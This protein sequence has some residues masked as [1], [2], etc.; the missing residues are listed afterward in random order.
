MWNFVD[1]NHE[2]GFEDVHRKSNCDIA[3]QNMKVFL[4]TKRK[5]TSQLSSEQVLVIICFKVVKK[6]QE[7]RF[8]SWLAL[9]VCTTLIFKMRENIFNIGHGSQVFSTKKTSQSFIF[10]SF[11]V[12]QT[13]QFGCGFQHAYCIFVVEQQHSKLTIFC[14]TE[15]AT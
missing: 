3:K 15:I 1:R 5:L 7:D 13:K 10:S 4:P 9:R 14:E 11:H 6:R 12:F 2:A 8:K